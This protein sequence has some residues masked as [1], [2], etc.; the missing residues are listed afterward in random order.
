MLIQLPET[1][2][3][4]HPARLPHREGASC[5]VPAEQPRWARKEA[6]CLEAILKVSGQGQEGPRW[7]KGGRSQGLTTAHPPLPWGSSAQRE[8][9]AVGA[10]GLS[11]RASPLT[12]RVALR[13]SP[14][15]SEFKPSPHK[16]PSCYSPTPQTGFETLSLSTPQSAIRLTAPWQ[17][18]PQE[19][20]SSMCTGLVH[21]TSWGTY[22]ALGGFRILCPLIYTTIQGSRRSLTPIGRGGKEVHAMNEA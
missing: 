1:L 22:C 11:P 21:A 5:T 6:G 2:P 20:G 7:Q 15:V 16:P 8:M 9:S 19:P 12:H 17:P 10:P 18:E 14:R 3:H 4:P 13:E